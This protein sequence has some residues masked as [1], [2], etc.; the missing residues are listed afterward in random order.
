MSTITDAYV[1]EMPNH[2]GCIATLDGYPS[3]PIFEQVLVGGV[4]LDVLQIHIHFRTAKDIRPY[5]GLDM[6]GRDYTSDHFIG[7]EVEALPCDAD[8][9]AEKG[10]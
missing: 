10:E 4:L 2:R 9:Q 7:L 8:P 1:F 3:E 5:L 6:E